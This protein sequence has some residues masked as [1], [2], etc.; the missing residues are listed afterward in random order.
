M[1]CRMSRNVLLSLF[2]DVVAAEA[3]PFEQQEAE[4][5]DDCRSVTGTMEH[6]RKYFSE[7][8]SHAQLDRGI[9]AHVRKSQAI[10]VGEKIMN[11][12]GNQCYSTAFIAFNVE[13]H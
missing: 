13:R 4:R 10:E 2:V 12:S 5:I 3:D 1:D 7:C 11:L 9:S 8:R 6:S